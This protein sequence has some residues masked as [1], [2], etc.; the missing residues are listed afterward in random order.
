MD[1][2]RQ[3]FNICGKL[4]GDTNENEG[5]DDQ[6]QNKRQNAKNGNKEKNWN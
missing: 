1:L 3:M 6:H 4:G 2:Q 5:I